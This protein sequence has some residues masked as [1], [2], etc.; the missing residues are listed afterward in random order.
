MYVLREEIRYEVRKIRSELTKVTNPELWPESAITW[1]KQAIRAT[2][3][4][5]NRNPSRG[6][7]IGIL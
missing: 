2:N 4:Q 5:S 1:K 7:A 6:P 3:E